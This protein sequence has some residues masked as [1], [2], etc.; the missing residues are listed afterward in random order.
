M[1]I[2]I[3]LG[4]KGERFS[5]DGFTSPKPLIQ[6]FEKCMIDYVIDNL[7]ISD[8][9]HVFII[10]NANLDNY[11]FSTYIHERYPF[12]QLINIC[13]TKGAAETLFLGI[14]KIIGN[15]KYNEK[16]LI[17]DCDTFYTQDIRNIFNK[18]NNN[19]VF[20][21]KNTEENPIYSYI[22]LDDECIIIDIKEKLKISDNA[23]TGA[24]AFTD[25]NVLQ[26][27]CQHILDNNITF[28]NEPY[29]S[30]VISE[31]INNKIKFIGYELNENHV[32][33]LGT[34]NAVKKYI[35]DTYAFLFD[36]D[37]TIV[38]TDDIYFD[39]WYKILLK[40]NIVLTTQIFKTFIQGNNDKYVLNTLISNIDLQLS[41]LSA[42]KDDLFI[43]SISKIKTTDGIYNLLN[44]IR[45][46]G[47]KICIVTNCN[48]KVVN[49]I[50]KYIDI[51]KY[52]DFI[53]TS[54]DCIIGKP[55]PEPYMK[56]I[57]KYNIS[58]N[59]SIIFEDSKTG[60]LSGKKYN[61]KIIGRNRN[62]LQLR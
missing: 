4:G 37:G 60:I 51:E 22:M 41:E 54:E 2:I 49:E 3:P 56:A 31:M 52:I 11:Q 40:Y 12:I 50:V 45:V 39:V 59:K 61:S 38:I 34:P 28:N 1:N 6:I 48:R 8:K 36:L 53:I 25:I 16:C 62:N 33:S 58:N 19:I 27:Y 23:N 9:D 18:T 20:Y 46:A 44:E 57:N 47:H 15:Y 55:D 17:L 29:T 13:D 24:Y 43:K 7:Y 42:I 26:E 21:T 5:K 14:E 32:F 35:D 10:Y 30:C